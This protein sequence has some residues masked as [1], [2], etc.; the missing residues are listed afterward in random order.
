MIPGEAA[1]LLKRRRELA[2]ETQKLTVDLE[3]SCAAV[4]TASASV[5]GLIGIWAVELYVNLGHRAVLDTNAQAWTPSPI[6]GVERRI[7]DRRGEE[8]IFVLDG[9][10]QGEYGSDPAQLAAQSARQRALAL[11]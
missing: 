1:P 6:A 2:R 9:V 11:K 10:S 4:G 7:L 5:A 8:E 3:G